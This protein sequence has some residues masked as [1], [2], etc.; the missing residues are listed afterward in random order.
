MVS[1]IAEKRDSD[2]L[3]RSPRLSPLRDNLGGEARMNGVAA[4]DTAMVG[5]DGPGRDSTVNDP[6]FALSTGTSL[7]GDAYAGGGDDIEDKE[8]LA[9]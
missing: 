1:G 6:S 2:Q 8:L 5:I 7:G 4:D 3:E 9:T